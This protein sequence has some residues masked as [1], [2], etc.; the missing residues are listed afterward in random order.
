MVGVS[1]GDLVR[2]IA[3]HTAQAAVSYGV[4]KAISRIAGLRGAG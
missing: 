3:V 2:G 1:I 4:G